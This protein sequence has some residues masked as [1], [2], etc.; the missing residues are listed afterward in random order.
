MRIYLCIICAILQTERGRKTAW[1][2]CGTSKILTDGLSEQPGK[3][4]KKASIG[5]ITE[6]K[7]VR[8]ISSVN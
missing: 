5:K 7:N 2:C 1:N 4:K 6:K 3:K 8:E